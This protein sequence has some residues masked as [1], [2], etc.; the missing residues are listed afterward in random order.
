MCAPL[1]ASALLALL[2]GVLAGCGSSSTTG[3]SADPASAV[4]ASAALYAGATVRPTGALETNA[5]AAGKAL[6]HQTDPYLRL[7]AILQT[8]GSATLNFQR[9]V[10]PWL[11]THAGVFLTSLSSASALPAE[12]GQGLLGGSSSGT[13]PFGTGRA[14]GA[15]VLDT[16]DAAKAG[17]FLTTQAAKRAG[18]TRRATAV[19]PTRSTPKAWPSGWSTASPSSAA[20]RGCTA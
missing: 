11:G 7:L 16:S 8:P 3:T 1:A 13:F 17:S 18:R 12:L 19:S 2:G 6:T 10:A 15:I 20:N 5:L 14:Q 9:D 4:P